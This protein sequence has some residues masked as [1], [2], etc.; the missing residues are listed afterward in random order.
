MFQLVLFASCPCTLEHRVFEVHVP[1]SVWWPS[2][3]SPTVPMSLM[4]WGAQYWTQQSSVTSLV[5]STAQNVVVLFC[6][7]CMCWPMITLLP[8][9]TSRP[10]RLLP[11]Q[12]ALRHRRQSFLSHTKM[13]KLQTD[14]GESRIR[15]GKKE[16]NLT[17]VSALLCISPFQFKVIKTSI[18]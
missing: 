2:P 13:R 3:D 17:P 8:T 14:S 4:C 16:K 1:Q 5:L 9:R 10:Y 15:R 12:L 11:S 7:K 6:H 18:F